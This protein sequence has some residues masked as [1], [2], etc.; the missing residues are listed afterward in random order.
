VGSEEVSRGSYVP[1]SSNRA[2]LSL[3]S[4]GIYVS[5]R[6]QDVNGA[7][8]HF[9]GPPVEFQE[10]TLTAGAS[11]PSQDATSKNAVLASLAMTAGEGLDKWGEGA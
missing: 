6:Q 7:P 3:L 9:Q 2:A 8:T 10:K 4:S 1:R 5:W 11:I